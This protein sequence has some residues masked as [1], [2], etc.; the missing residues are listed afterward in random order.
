M[1]KIFLLLTLSF[2]ICSS[3]WAQ[4]SFFFSNATACQGD[5]F[6]VNITVSNFSNITTAQFRVE[7][8][9]A[10]IEYVGAQNPSLPGFNVGTNIDANNSPS[11]NIDINWAV[12]PCSTPGSIGVTL[13]DCFG[14]CRP[15]ILQLRYV[16]LSNTYGETSSVGTGPNPY[17]TKDNSSCLNVGL[18][19]HPALISNCVRPV[20]LIA[21]QRQ[22]NPGDLV[23]IDFRVT[24]FD[25]LNSMQFSINYD[26]TVLNFE[27]VVIPG[28]LPNFTQAASL[29]LPPN[30][31]EGNITVS[32]LYITPENT[33]ISLLDSTIIFQA[34]FRIV[35][36]CESATMISFGNNPTPIEIGNTIVQNFN[37]LVLRRSG[38]VQVSNC[39]PTGMAMAVDCGPARN[40][41][42]TFCVDVTAT[43]FFNVAK[44]NYLVE[45]NPSILQF[46]GI[47]NVTTNGIANFNAVSNFN[48][49]NVQGG[50]LGV[51]WERTGFNN[52]FIPNGVVHYQLCFEVIGV[53]GNSP[54]QITG[55]VPEVRINTPFAP[56]IGINPSNCE[57]DINQ[58]SGVTLRL[59]DGEATLNNQ[60]CVDITTANFTNITR[61]RYSL[62]WDPLHLQFVSIQNLSLPGVSP[63]INFGQQGASSGVVTFE[64]NTAS[65]VTRPDGTALFRICFAVIGT[66]GDCDEVMIN[67]DPLSREAVT[68]F[69]NGNNIG[70]VSQNGTICSLFPEGFFMTVGNNQTFWRD[71]TCVPFRVSSFD[72][73]TEAH[74][75]V[76]FNPVH[77][78][79]VGVRNLAT[80]G[81]L[82][83]GS[84]NDAQSALGIIEFDWVNFAG[85]MLADST[86]LFEMCFTAIGDA[87]GACYPIEVIREPAPGVLTTAG[88]GSLV[89]R[90]G[91]VCVND[92]L[93]VINAVITPVS[94][95][96]AD[97]GTIEITVEG[98]LPPYGTTWESSPLQF[99]PLSARNLP[100]GPIVVTIWDGR[101]PAT[102]RLDTFFIPLANDIPVANAGPDRV[103]PCDGSTLLGVQGTG[104]TGTGFTTQWSTLGGELAN[105]TN[106]PV[107][108]ALR[109]GIYIFAVTNTETGCTVRDT[110]NVL[111]PV[112]PIA[113]AGDDLPTTCL[114]DTLT[115]NGSLSSTGDT[116]SYLW[117]SP[118]GGQIL[119]GT[120]N[121]PKPGGRR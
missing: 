121:T 2:T 109:Q 84:F 26:P 114:S 63:L 86:I 83:P 15:T 29:G 71:T 113:N 75:D 58:P 87:D 78:E 64:W 5:T 36:P 111:N 110:M 17:L 100:P 120:Q 52:A 45:W 40:L 105:P 119:L 38:R 20:E 43:D 11:G 96:G 57:V 60:L 53:G 118:S 19:D 90:N 91:R 18:I 9:A 56:N 24:G 37:I 50:I 82:T 46:Q 47:A 98:G 94:C 117:T 7:W 76:S 101:I 31:P 107:G 95:P 89:W 112:F 61:L 23:C 34:C 59:Q 14:T 93:Y 80:L 22:G 55:P 72:N 48:T 12:A 8:D 27:N 97:D 21:S 102:I 85:G 30:I 49:S 70:I 28:A 51:S 54:V 41:G 10:V 42:E 79:Y 1:K 25:D 62:N 99:M 35:G 116:I 69:S 108:L 73:I 103:F 39:A 44:F 68:S 33:G 74:F 77:L 88:V 3:I 81:G 32:W 92:K 115:L 67:D 66:P 13:N 65:P 6:L 104:T 106:T 4:P 16:M